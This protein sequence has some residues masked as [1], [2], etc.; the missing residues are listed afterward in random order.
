V[1]SQVP[2]FFNLH[3]RS[4]IT[5]VQHWHWSQLQHCLYGFVSDTITRLMANVLI[6]FR[7]G[8]ISSLWGIQNIGRNFGIMMY[9]PFTGTPLFSYMYALISASHKEEGETICRGRSCWQLTFHLA[10]VASCISML[11][12]IILWRRWRGKI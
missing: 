7:P 3:T 2:I 5:F 6:A 12:S 9:A 11:N 1:G 4:L 8:L 10:I